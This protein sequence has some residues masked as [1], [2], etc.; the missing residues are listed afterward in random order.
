MRP[1][2][3]RGDVALLAEALVTL[4]ASSAA[5][6]VLPFSRVGRMA[7]R[8]LGDRARREGPEKIVW[9]VRAWGR[10]VPWR[11]VCFQQGLATQLMLRRRGLDSTLYFGASPSTE[12]GLA[13]HVWVKIGDTD[14]IGCEDSAK[15][16]VLA[17]FPSRGKISQGGPKRFDAN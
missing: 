9:A 10:R 8:S 7:S 17:K 14:M 6:R 11:A 12:E 5:I 16:A 15:Y 13:A 1:R 2:L 3:A 4:V